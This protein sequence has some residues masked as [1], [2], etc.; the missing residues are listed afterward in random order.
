MT[1]R[2]LI[3]G[4]A[5]QGGSYLAELLLTTGHEVQGLKRRASAFGTERVDHLCLDL[6]ETCRMF[7]LHCGGPADS[8]NRTG[9][10]TKAQLDEI[11]KLGAQ[12]NVQVRF[13]MS[14][15]TADMNLQ[16]VAEI[17]P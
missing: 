9:T 12:S 16:A 15:Y 2:A 3:T 10:V 4:I 8:R 17:V 13:E 6:Q 14:E 11:H 5:G 1:T 7:H